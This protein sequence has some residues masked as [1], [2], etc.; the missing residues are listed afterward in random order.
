MPTTDKPNNDDGLTLLD[1][2]RALEDE[3]WFL[4]LAAQKNAVPAEP[5]NSFPSSFAARECRINRSSLRH[6]HLHMLS[7]PGIGYNILL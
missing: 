6:D 5:A 3:I 4:A 7:Y 2:K 1:Q